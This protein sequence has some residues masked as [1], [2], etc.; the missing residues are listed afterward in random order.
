MRLAAITASQS[1]SFQRLESGSQDVGDPPLEGFVKRQR[2]PGELGDHRQRQVV[3]GR[4]EPAAGD[5]QV[6][7]LL[8]VK[9]QLGLH[10]LGAIAA[11][12]D[13]RQVD[14][15]L[16]QPV[17]QPRAVAVLDPAGQHLGAGDDDAGARA[18]AQGLEPAGS[19]FVAA[20]VNSNPTGSELSGIVTFF[21]FTVTTSPRLPRFTRSAFLSLNVRFCSSVPS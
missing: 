18:H 15:Q 11:D 21:P 12:G 17:R 7:P 10:V 6:D 13:R 1:R 16:A 20:C 9:A 8:A 5:D 4:A 3:R 19:S 14:P 2:A